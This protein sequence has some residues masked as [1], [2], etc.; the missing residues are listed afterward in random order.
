MT[1]YA[2]AIEKRTLL[3]H[4]ATNDHN[5]LCGKSIDSRPYDW[6]LIEF[7]WM[8]YARPYP[9]PICD[10]KVRYARA[11]PWADARDARADARAR[12]IAAKAVKHGRSKGC[13][14]SRKGFR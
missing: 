5:T 10:A 6:E 14:G 12:D 1:F 8:S 11:D 2:K 13:C 9:C 3:A 4:I 7:P